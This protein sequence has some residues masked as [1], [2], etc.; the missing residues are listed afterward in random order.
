MHIE[1]KLPVASE[2]NYLLTAQSKKEASLYPIITISESPSRSIFNKFK[3]YMGNKLRQT[4]MFLPTSNI[5]FGIKY[6]SL[7][8]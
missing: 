8:Y 2:S 3:H 1:Q 7:N 4:S 5:Q 6:V